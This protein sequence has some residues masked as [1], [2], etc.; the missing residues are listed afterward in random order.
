MVIRRSGEPRVLE[1]FNAIGEATCKSGHA[2]RSNVETASD[3]Q[4]S[5]YSGMRQ[6]FARI[7]VRE[8]E[9]LATRRRPRSHAGRETRVCDAASNR[10]SDQSYLE[11]KK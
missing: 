1:H 2:G 8:F 9:R 6:K 3:S 4:D 5:A 11:D 7:A 10:N